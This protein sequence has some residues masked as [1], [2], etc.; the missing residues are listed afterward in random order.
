MARDEDATALEH[1][2]TDADGTLGTEGPGHV[3]AGNETVLGV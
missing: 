1:P 2:E 3:G